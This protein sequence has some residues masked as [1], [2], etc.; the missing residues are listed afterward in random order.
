MSNTP[1]RVLGDGA[2]GDIN[3]PEAKDTDVVVVV[4]DPSGGQATAELRA[5][6]NKEEKANG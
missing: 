1:E 3:N 4:A 6:L 5:A 2:A